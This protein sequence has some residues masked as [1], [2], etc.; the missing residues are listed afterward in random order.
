MMAYSPTDKVSVSDKSVGALVSISK[1]VGL[2][3]ELVGPSVKFFS[4]LLL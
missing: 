1:S 3:G 2:F 4:K